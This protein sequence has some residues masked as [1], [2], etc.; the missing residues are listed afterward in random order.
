MMLCVS[1][2]I[3]LFFLLLHIQIHYL[4]FLEKLI[5]QFE[6]E[7]VPTLKLGQSLGDGARKFTAK[8]KASQTC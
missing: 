6:G 5:A 7:G 1:F 8:T 2:S 3:I 4:I